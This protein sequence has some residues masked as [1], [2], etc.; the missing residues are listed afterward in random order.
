MANRNRY[1]SLAERYRPKTLDEFVGNTHLKKFILSQIKKKAFPRHLLVTGTWGSGKT[2]IARI[3]AKYAAC[4]DFSACGNCPSCKNTISEVKCVEEYNLAE[5]RTKKNLQRIT[6]NFSGSLFYKRRVCICDEAHELSPSL[7]PEWE[8]FIK[9]SA[10]N[11]HAFWIILAHTPDK[12]PQQ[13][14]EACKHFELQLPLKN[15]LISHLNSI[16]SSEG[17]EVDSGADVVFEKITKIGKRNI[18]KSIKL[19][20]KVLS[21]FDQGKEYKAICDKL[22]RIVSQSDF[23]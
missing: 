15:H 19:L 18:R 3:I 21:D 6:Y 20:E 22:D 17:I 1:E 7:F 16:L 11:T 5:I 23:L 13:I 10:P 9:S 4:E 12:I 14:R 2:S 8:K